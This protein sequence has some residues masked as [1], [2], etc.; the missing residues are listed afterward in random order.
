I[1]GTITKYAHQ[2]RDPQTIRVHLEKAYH[3]A[4][5]G[6]PGTVLIDLP[7][8]LQRAE[9]DPQTMPGFTP[10]RLEPHPL[11]AEIVDLLDRLQKARRPVLVLGGGLTTP[12][13]GGDL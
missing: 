10:E 5:D 6:R 4:F 12:R 1:F 13:L 11:Q 8:D 9:V 3:L 2:I 7:D